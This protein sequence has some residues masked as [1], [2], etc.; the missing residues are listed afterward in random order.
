MFSS[1]YFFKKKQYKKVIDTLSKTAFV[2]AN[3]NEAVSII[4]V[5]ENSGTYNMYNV[6]FSALN[7]LCLLCL[8]FSAFSKI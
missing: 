7:L 8:V 6:M 2:S 4:P 1:I 3:G 5:Y